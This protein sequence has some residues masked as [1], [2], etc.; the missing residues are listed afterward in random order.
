MDAFVEL[1][2]SH[3]HAELA[4]IALAGQQYPWEL[5]VIIVS[6]SLKSHSHVW[7][8]LDLAG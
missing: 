3:T 1:E 8:T 7:L 6:P 2:L 5:L 4:T